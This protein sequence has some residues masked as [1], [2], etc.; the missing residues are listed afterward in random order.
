MVQ[1]KA[2]LQ[3]TTDPMLQSRNPDLRKTYVPGS[4]V[5]S[6]KNPFPI[7]APPNSGIVRPRAAKGRA[8]WVILTS[9]ALAQGKP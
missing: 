2:R 5:I 8:D 1:S 9:K 6:V 3:S 4:R 7:V